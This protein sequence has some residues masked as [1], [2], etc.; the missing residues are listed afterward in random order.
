VNPFI[1]LDMVG[2]IISGGQTGAD[3]AALDFAMENGIA[4]GGWC[5]LG[6]LAEDGAIPEKYVLKEAATND[7]RDRTLRNVMEADGTLIF[8][9]DRLQGGTFLTY[10][11]AKKFGRPTFLAR[12]PT[13][14]RSRQRARKWLLDHGIHTLNIAGPRASKDER[15]YQA[16][17]DYLGQLFDQQQPRLPL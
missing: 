17:L 14:S 6:R 13:N 11:Y 12:L 3:R 9:F 1:Q 10:R 2:K 5:P 15:I 7:Y 4:H 16:V 8:Y